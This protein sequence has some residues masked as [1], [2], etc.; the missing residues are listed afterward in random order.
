[1]GRRQ[2]IS[3][4]KVARA[5]G[6]LRGGLSVSQTA[7][8][9][10]IGESVVRQI[11]HGKHSLQQ[12]ATEPSPR[13]SRNQCSDKIFR[14]TPEEIKARAWTIRMGWSEAQKR[15]GEGVQPVEV[16]FETLPDSIFGVVPPEVRT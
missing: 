6:L 14:P 13:N 1:M 7:K 16:V 11:A 3:Q 4:A 2:I 10:D 12:P 15:R 5:A 9:L 8:R